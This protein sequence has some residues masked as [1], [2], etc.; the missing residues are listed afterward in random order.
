MAAAWEVY[1]DDKFH[2]YFEKKLQRLT[3]FWLR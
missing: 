1:T 2:D 3:A